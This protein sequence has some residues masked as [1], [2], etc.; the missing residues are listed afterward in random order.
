MIEISK[1]LF[2]KIIN[3]NKLDVVVCAHFYTDTIE[4]KFEFRNRSLFGKV[5]EDRHSPYPHITRYYIS[6]FYYKKYNVENYEDITSST[7]KGVVRND[8]E[9]R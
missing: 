6:E 5:V 9:W 1:E 4:C 3:Y 8:R 7:Q 2:Y